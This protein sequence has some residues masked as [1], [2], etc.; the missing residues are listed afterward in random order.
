M[1]Y[2]L[3]SL[4]EDP[5]QG[6]R[7]CATLEPRDVKRWPFA[8]LAP[9]RQAAEAALA[10]FG[11]GLAG[12]IVTLGDGQS[13]QQAGPLLFHLGLPRE[14]GGSLAALVHGHLALLGNWQQVENRC[15]V[16]ALDLLRARDDNQRQKVEFAAIKGNLIQELEQ[17]KA[18]Q[19]ELLAVRNRLEA[20]LDA[21]PDL[22]FEVGLDGCI[23]DYH[24]PRSDLLA[25]PPE[26]FLNRNMAEVVPPEVAELVQSA[27]REAHETGRTAGT[28]YELT[29]PQGRFWFEL[30]GS[31]K[32]VD[33]GEQ[34]RFILLARDIT[35]RKEFERE[36][37]KIEKLESLG[38]L[39]GGI[40]HDFNNLL[41]AIM[42]NLSFA[43]LFLDARHKSY[44]PLVE[45]EKA[46][47]RAKDLSQQLLTFARGGEPVK[48]LL[49]VRELVQETVSLLLH[50]S[51]VK[52]HLDIP[53]GL[54]GI[55]ADEGQLSQ[56]WGNLILNAAQAMPGGGTLAIAARNE[57]LAHPNAWSLPGGNYLRLSFTDQGCGIPQEDLVRIFDPYFTT[58][59]KGKGLGLASVHS[60]I[61]RHGGHVGASSLPGQGTT[62]TVYL[63]STGEPCCLE[64]AEDEQPPGSASGIGSI[65]V[66][67]DERFILEMTA[68]MLEFLGYRVTRCE[69]G[70]QAVELYREAG[71]AGRPF[72]AVIMD[73]TI[74][75]GMGGRDAAVHILALDPKACLIV[76]SGYST[77][78]VLANF[79]SYG[80]SGA[81]VKPYKM[82]ELEQQLG[83]LLAAR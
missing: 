31:T 41:T 12:I 44:Q 79:A 8:L 13:W 10:P 11:P 70:E 52:A 57:S 18:M 81:V 5:P 69:S 46:S 54:H 61:G 29:L 22:L 74:P 32:A 38:V 65:L 9:D 68:N 28:Q 50:G 63:P 67:D 3:L 59:L 48:K 83:A 25:A 72:S 36:Q 64:P 53:D 17:R 16:Q 33:P 37:L 20:T 27:L 23:Y 77:D 82:R 42:G 56:A 47:V 40:A 24:S 62:F 19:G 51:N 34:P 7:H 2:R 55:V 6:F 21:V 1:E 66:M 30:S 39:A 73:L 80:F 75:G 58:K 15:G 35:D 45:A 4:L 76:S 14:F 60:I 26:V 43:Q 71:A 49:A 78:P